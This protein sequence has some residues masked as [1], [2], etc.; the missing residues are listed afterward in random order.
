VSKR[1]EHNPFSGFQPSKEEEGRK[2]KGG[3]GREE[4]KE[5]SGGG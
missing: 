3:A 2:E 5:K 1:K 4:R